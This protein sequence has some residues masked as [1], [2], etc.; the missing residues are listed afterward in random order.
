M[1]SNFDL[2]SSYPNVEI[3]NSFLSKYVILSFF[4]LVLE[5]RHLSLFPTSEVETSTWQIGMLERRANFAPLSLHSH[6]LFSVIFSSGVDLEMLK[7]QSSPIVW[8]KR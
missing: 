4:D 5:K 1:I 6:C 8:R 2:T 3:V 7:N